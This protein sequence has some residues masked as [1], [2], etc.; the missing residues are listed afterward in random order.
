M[1]RCLNALV[2][3]VQVGRARSLD[4]SK[5]P[6]KQGPNSPLAGWEGWGVAAAENIPSATRVRSLWLSSLAQGGCGPS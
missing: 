6:G 1:G 4:V 3:P 2:S 5:R